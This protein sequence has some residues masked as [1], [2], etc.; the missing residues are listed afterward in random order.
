[1]SSRLT[2][3]LGLV[4]SA[5]VRQ[6]FFKYLNFTFQTLLLMPLLTGAAVFVLLAFV[7]QLGEVYLGIIERG[8]VIRGGLGLSALMLL[9]AFL[10]AWHSNASSHKIDAL[11]P[12]HADLYFDRR[13]ALI[14]DWKALLCSLLPLLGLNLGLFLLLVEAGSV[15]A[16]YVDTFQFLWPQ[17]PDQEGVEL[18]ENLVSLPAKVFVTLL[19]VFIA[20]LAYG[21]AVHHLKSRPRVGYWLMTCLFV[22]APAVVVLP[23][24]LKEAVIPVVQGIGPLATIAL[25]LIAVSFVIYMCSLRAWL[26]G[27]V[28][29]G[30]LGWL[31]L[32]VGRNLSAQQPD[33]ARLGSSQAAQSDPRPLT[34]KFDQWLTSRPDRKLYKGKYPVFIFAAQGGGIYAASA[35]AGYLAQLQEHCPH[36]ASHVFA[37]SGVSGGA[38]GATLFN[39]LAA[40]ELPSA[41]AIGCRTFVSKSMNKPTLADRVEEVLLGDHLSPVVAATLP[42]FV[43]KLD[44]ISSGDVPSLDRAGML[45]RSFVRAFSSVASPLPHATRCDGGVSQGL[46]DRFGEH[47]CPASRMPA[48]LLN[49]TWVE[50]GYRV[51]FSPLPL[52]PVGDGTLWAFSDLVDELKARDRQGSASVLQSETQKLSVIQAAVVSARFPAVTPAWWPNTNEQ[53]WNFVDGGYAEGSGSAT[54]LDLYKALQKHAEGQGVDLRLVLITDTDA[55]VGANPLR[56]DGTTLNDTVTVISALLNVRSL[57]SRRAVTEAVSQLNL[58]PDP[59]IFVVTLD[60]QAFP[61]PLGWKISHMSHDIVQFVLGRPDLCQGQRASAPYVPETNRASAA[62]GS[63]WEDPKAARKVERAVA[64]VLENSCATQRIIDLLDPSAAPTRLAIAQRRR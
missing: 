14:R 27:A 15:R 6:G 23:F 48:L 42:D 45:E 50:S 28:L 25:V 24:L 54:A 35:A 43:R 18:R 34:Q 49:A 17:G 37:I 46:S 10:Y 60:H 59:K 63:S 16:I 56:F 40:R 58:S 22:V 55:A 2:V 29:I 11:Y 7:P 52:R 20:T 31:A 13:L 3:L 8:D 21:V 19:L 5:D 61:L 57:L 41:T 9:S 12:D 33:E 4:P 36:F 38:V 64:T 26:L 53:R 32:M 44:F 62:Q 30:G 1:M 47:W 51:A 39:A